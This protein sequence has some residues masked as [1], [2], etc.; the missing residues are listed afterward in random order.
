MT[1]PVH[2]GEAERW[3]SWSWRPPARGAHFRTCSYCGSIHPEDLAAETAGGPRCLTCGREGWEACFR[4]QQ[5]IW[6]SGTEREAV[7]AAIDAEERT[8]IET[9][10]PQHAYDC[11]GWRASWA[12]QKY[13][14]PHKFYVEGLRN[15]NPRQLHIISAVTKPEQATGMGLQWVPAGEIPEGTV[16]DGWRDLE[17]TYSHVGLG[18]RETHFAKF[19]TIHLA[20]P[21]ISGEAKETVQRVSGLRFTFTED[22]RVGWQRYKPPG[23]A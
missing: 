21:Q 12:D 6:A 11:G 9:L 22:G 1:N 14:W 5:P 16:T 10:A 19:Y 2:A 8:R 17:G 13:G 4:N 3:G 23:Q 15:R 7:M 18:T 20:D